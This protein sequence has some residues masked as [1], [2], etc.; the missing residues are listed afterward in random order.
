[1]TI[2]AA[3]LD[4]PISIA[5]NIVGVADHNHTIVLNPAQLAQIKAK[6]PVTV[7]SS[8]EFAHFHDV[9]VNCA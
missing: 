7:V 1:L 9:T 6:T 3:D 8:V 4:S 5:Y 2:P